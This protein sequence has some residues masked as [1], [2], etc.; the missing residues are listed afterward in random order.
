MSDKHLNALVDSNLSTLKAAADLLKT[1]STEEFTVSHQPYFDSSP[2]KHLRHVL[3]HYLCFRGGFTAGLINY[4]QRSRDGRLESD[5]NHALSIIQQLCDFLD[6][7]RQG[8]RVDRPLAVLMCNDVALPRGK[9]TQSSLGRELQFLQGHSVHHYALI[10]AILRF[11]GKTLDPQFGVAP[12]T[13][14]YEETTKIVDSVK[15]SA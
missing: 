6:P 2:G 5:K 15:E 1:L 3:D 9:I 8:N 7:L 12:S 4:D 13:L 14:V 10:A 11:S